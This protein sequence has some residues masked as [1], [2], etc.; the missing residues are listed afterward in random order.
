MLDMSAVLLDPLISS[1]FDVKRQHE[2]VGTSGR[3]TKVPEWYRDQIGRVKPEEPSSLMRR[4]DGQ[5]APQVISVI[6][7]FPLRKASFGF[8]P[9][10][11]VYDGVEYMVTEALA[12]RVAG[13]TK[14]TAR[15]TRAMDSPQKED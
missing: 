5:M 6:T 14:A 13:F 9:D 3:A 1:R 10:L 12:Y 15:S 11:I 7:Q 2:S 8:Q 4:D